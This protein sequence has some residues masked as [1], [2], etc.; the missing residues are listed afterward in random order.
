MKFDNANSVRIRIMD[1]LAR[2]EHSSKEIYQK[3]KKKIDYLDILKQ[4]IKKLSDEG[5]IDNKR[6][7]EQYIHSRSNRGYG[8][9][10]IRQ[11]LIQKG[12]D[13]T[14]CQ[15]LIDSKDW[16]NLAKLALEK[17]TGKNIPEEGEKVLKIKR[18][19]NYRGFD[20]SHIEKA[21][22]LVREQ[23]ND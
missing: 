2:R 14:I 4:E 12:V 10:R 11:E 8:P 22:S 6:F 5:L 1:L 3:L 17:K 13:D 9:L 16:N 15:S 7:A 23:E 18:F 20:Y 21:I 19:L